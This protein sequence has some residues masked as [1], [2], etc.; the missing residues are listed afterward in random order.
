[1][2]YRITLAFVLAVAVTGCQRLPEAEDDDDGVMMMATDASTGAGSFLPIDSSDSGPGGDEVGESDCQP[3][4]QTGCGPG[5][6]CTA[7][8]VGASVVYVCVGDSNMFDPFGSCMPMLSSGDD[9]CPAG[10]ACLGTETFGACVPLCLS[11]ADCTGGVCVP[12]PIDFVQHC[13]NDCSPFEPSCPTP[14][15]CRRQDDRYACV[16]ARDEDSGVAGDPCEVTDDAGC[17]TGFACFPGALVPDCTNNGCCTT[18]CDLTGPDPCP[19]PSLCSPAIE[20]AAPGFEHIGA[21]FV[22]A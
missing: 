13:A 8:K 10:Y 6:K 17:A 4:A 7:Q 11:D 14:L 19:A 12:D 9:G 1:M 20:N 22:E 21:C 2:A 15:Q 5:E 3:V 18:L 16:F